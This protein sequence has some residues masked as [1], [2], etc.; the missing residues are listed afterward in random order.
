MPAREPVSSVFDFD[1]DFDLLL[2]DIP[3]QFFSHS[4]DF[5]CDMRNRQVMTC[6]YK[7]NKY[8]IFLPPFSKGDGPPAGQA[9]GIMFLILILFA[10]YSYPVLL[11]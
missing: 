8:E 6:L 10:C 1:F 5:F 11:S 9:G 4:I 7:C 3:I 2:L